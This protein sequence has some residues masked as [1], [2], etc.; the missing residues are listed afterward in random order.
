M[1]QR[2]Y[3]LSPRARLVERRGECAL[4]CDHPLQK[5]RLD[6]GAWRLLRALDGRTPLDALARC[7]TP[8]WVRFLEQLTARGLLTATYRVQPPRDWP[9]VEVIVP[10]Y[11]EHPAPLRECLAGL[12]AQTYPADRF[13]VTVV[14]DASPVDLRAALAAERT[15]GPPLRWLRLDTNL[16]PASARNAAAFDTRR[17]RGSPPAP[18][19]AFLDS[20]CVPEPGWLAGLVGVLEDPAIAAAGAQWEGRWGRCGPLRCLAAT[21][22]P[23]PRCSWVRRAG[24]WETR[25]AGLPICPRPIWPSSAPPSH[26]WAAFARGCGWPRTWI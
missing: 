4:L 2:R 6:A 5:V 25:R 3:R 22:R 12:E 15:Q 10:V 14:D 16:G 21:R 1:L 8:A 18:L 17:G 13:T 19:L 9:A 11:A 20:D 7:A 23:A 24:R 26:G